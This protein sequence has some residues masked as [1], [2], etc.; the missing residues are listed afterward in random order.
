VKYIWYKSYVNCGCR[1]KRRMIIEVN[2]Q[3]SSLQLL[4]LEILL[5]WSFFNVIYNRSSHMNYFIY[6][7]HHCQLFIG[8]KF[9]IW[10]L[11]VSAVFIIV[12]LSQS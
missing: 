9:W 3:A 10:W 5:R 4:K 1:W 8:R 7:S 2:F 12:D 6:T 11:P